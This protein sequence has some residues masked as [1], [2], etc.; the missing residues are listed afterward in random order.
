MYPATANALAHE[1]Q[2]ITA[3]AKKSTVNLAS[4]NTNDFERN[5]ACYNCKQ[6]GHKAS[7]CPRNHI[8]TQPKIHRTFS[9]PRKLVI[10][11][12]TKW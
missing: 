1:T 6:V 9:R 12:S 8:Q 5:I 2:L 11:R 7:A 3:Q 10:S 4:S